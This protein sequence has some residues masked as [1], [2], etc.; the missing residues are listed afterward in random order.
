MYFGTIWLPLFFNSHSNSFPSLYFHLAKILFTSNINSSIHSSFYF[1]LYNS[2]GQEPIH[3]INNLQVREPL[4][5][6]LSGLF[7]LSGLFLGMNAAKFESQKIERV[8]LNKREI[9]KSFL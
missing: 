4:L 2:R 3:L 9:K 5:P 1:I 7:G 8:F 6:M